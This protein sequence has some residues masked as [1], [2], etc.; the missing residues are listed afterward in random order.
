MRAS[1]RDLLEYTPNPGTRPRPPT[2]QQA[3]V[4]FGSDWSTIRLGRDFAD[5]D[6]LVIVDQDDQADSVLC[7]APETRLLDD[8]SSGLMRPANVESRYSHHYKINA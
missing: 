5:L 2:K 8:L 6:L 4:T 3:P 1:R 7:R